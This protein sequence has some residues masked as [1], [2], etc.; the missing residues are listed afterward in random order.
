MSCFS[1]EHTSAFSASD[2]ADVSTPSHTVTF[3]NVFLNE[4]GDFNS[5][6]G[7]FTCR[8]PGLY[9]FTASLTKRRDSVR[10]DWM[11]CTF[12]LNGHGKLEIR[13]DP[14]DDDTDKGSYSA[15]ASLILNLAVGD[16]LYLGSC[17]PAS[18]FDTNRSVFAGFLIRPDNL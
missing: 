13:I 9:F 15:S 12:M 2:L 7:V 11:Y 3:T 6:T 17:T 16:Y 4:G 8:I 1:G 5:V 18:Y 10:V 14:T